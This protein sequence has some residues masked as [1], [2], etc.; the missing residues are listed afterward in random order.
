MGLMHFTTHTG[1]RLERLLHENVS[2]CS[3][4]CVDEKKPVYTLFLRGNLLYNL[5]FITLSQPA[6]V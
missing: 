2:L 5:A 6:S 1:K 4:C 3:L